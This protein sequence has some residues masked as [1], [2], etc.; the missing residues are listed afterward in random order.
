M[1][2][3]PLFRHTS[4]D[5]TAEHT[6]LC[7]SAPPAVACGG[8]DHRAGY[9]TAAVRFL[10]ATTLVCTQNRLCRGRKLVVC[11]P[12]SAHPA[13]RSTPNFVLK[14]PHTNAPPTPHHK[15]PPHSLDCFAR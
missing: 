8:T 12:P 11:S 13:R 3:T 6:S 1:N 10:L 4:T 14:S 7:G 9:I 2:L 15:G 5:S